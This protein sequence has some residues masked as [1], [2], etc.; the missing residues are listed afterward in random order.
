MPPVFGC[1]IVRAY[2]HDRGAFT[3]GM[4]WAN[5][6]LHESTGLVGSSTIRQVRLRDG[7]VERSVAIADGL[8]G[9]GITLWGD[10]LLSATYRGG[11]GFRWCARTLAPRGS[12]S[13][14]GEGWGLTEDGTSI[15]LS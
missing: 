5:G 6:R 11:W 7:K 3:Q 14:D 8:F 12:F 1:R 13:Y 2:P 4:V 10:E 15:V 9:E